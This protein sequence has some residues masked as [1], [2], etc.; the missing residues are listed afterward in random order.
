ML[1]FGSSVLS[2]HYHTALL[3]WVTLTIFGGMYH[4]VP[5]L[6]WIEKYGGKIGKEKIPSVKE[7][8]DE[9]HANNVF[10]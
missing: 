2:L 6:I 3:C 9:K 5:M 10:G 7:M 4:I 1:V 8:Y